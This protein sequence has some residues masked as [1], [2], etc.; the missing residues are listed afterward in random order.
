[1][2]RPSESP[3]ATSDHRGWTGR[4]GRC[5]DAGSVPGEPGGW[6]RDA[7]EAPGERWDLGLVAVM[8]A[9]AWAGV[10]IAEDVAGI[11]GAVRSRDWAD[12]TLA[13]VAGALDGLSAVRDP[14]DA[15]KQIGA[16]WLIEHVRP[17]SEPLEWLAGDPAVI[18]THVWSLRDVAARLSAEAEELARAVGAEVPG[19]SGAAEKAYRAWIVRWTGELRTLGAAAVTSAVIAEESGGL[20]GSVRLM[21]RDAVETVVGRLIAGAA[22]LFAG[23]GAGAGTPA[24]VARVA[25]LCAVWAARISQWLKALISSLRQLLV[26][27]DRLAATVRKRACSEPRRHAPEPS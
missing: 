18:A 19:W 1:V 17:L 15:L 4:S 27:S 2:P 5:R 22:E 9:E 13:D 24:V 20:A 10:A 3:G 26:Q 21:I 16:D 25:A 8:N 11:G 23:A 12:G 7:G 14:L 6:C